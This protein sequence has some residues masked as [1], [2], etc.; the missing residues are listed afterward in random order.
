MLILAAMLALLALADLLTGGIAGSAGRDLTRARRIGLV[1]AA[2]GLGAAALWVGTGAVWPVVTMFVVGFPGALIWVEA[3]AAGDVGGNYPRLALVTLALTLL[4]A[5]LVLPAVFTPPDPRWLA[6][7]L[8]R[9]PWAAIRDIDPG[10]LP[11]TLAALLFLGPTANGVVRTCLQLTRE[12]PV[13][14]A[15]QQLKGGRFIG[16]LERYLIF[17]LALAGEPTAAALVISAKSIIRFPELQS[18]ATADHSTEAGSGKQV[19]PVD[20]LT[21]Y[22]L[23]GSLLS[24][25]LALAMTLPVLALTA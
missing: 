25:S 17:G 20:V 23:L 19:R 5:G 6:S 3:R 7:Y 9:L 10:V 21:E 15:E 18:K 12:T 4:I 24:W 14:E 2:A 16:P 22:F 8:S 11:L 13:A 1:T